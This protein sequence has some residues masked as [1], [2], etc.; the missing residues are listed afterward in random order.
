MKNEFGACGTVKLCLAMW[1]RVYTEKR[2]IKNP[3]F[4]LS[5]RLFSATIP[6]FYELRTKNY[7]L[8]KWF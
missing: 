6:L 8:K 5:N 1:S 7:E 4:L 2:R 3:G